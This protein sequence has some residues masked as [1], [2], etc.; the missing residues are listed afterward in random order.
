VLRGVHFDFNKAAVRADARPVLDEAAS[1][2]AARPAVRV[3]VEGHT[4][5]LGSD[6]YNQRLSERRA[7]AVLE[8]LVH[9]GVARERL[10]AQ[11]FGESHPVADNATEDGRARNR[12]VELRV[13][14]E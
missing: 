7:R 6:A 13:L 5:G 2:L 10:E 3:A 1:I 8:Y 11:G 12:R 9:A 4:D 14:S